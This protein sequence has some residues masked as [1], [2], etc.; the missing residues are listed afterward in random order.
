MKD[1]AA[2]LRSI[3]SKLNN[4]DITCNN[5]ETIVSERAAVKRR[6]ARVI[7]VT[8]GKGGVGK[9]NITIN[10]AI[11]ISQ[12]GL[13]VIVIDADLGLSN[14][15]IVL[16]KIPKYNLSDVIN[17]RRSIHEIIEE[18]P[19]G[20]KFISGGSGLQDLI[21]ISNEQLAYLLMELGK[22]DEEADIIFID[23][24][25]GISDQ[26]LSFVY[27]AKEVIVLTTPE[28]TAITDAYALIKVMA[29]KDKSKKI[30]L[31]LNKADSP[32]EANN[33][34]DK[35][36]QVCSKFLGVSIDKLGYVCNDSNISKAVK[37]QQPFIIAF[38]KSAAA[39]DISSIARSLIYI[40]DRKTEHGYGIRL[41]VNKLK[42]FF[43]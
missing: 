36:C 30:S 39:I 10:L 17:Y 13:K 5:N 8:S 25:A 24:G 28:P 34:L 15:D 35:L 27:A 1:Q 16:G 9:T 7:T 41:F 32:T 3:V 33:T 18:G 38:E 12:L 37:L 22:L 23:T 29:Q 14:V 26:V 43:K 20:V 19:G 11:K 2:K 6:N 31:L 21:K 40:D 4:A 42:W